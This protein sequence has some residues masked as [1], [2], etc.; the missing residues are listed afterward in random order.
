MDN[1]L[2]LAIDLLNDKEVRNLY[3]PLRFNSLNRGDTETSIK[4]DECKVDHQEKAKHF[5]NCCREE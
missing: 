4:Y 5:G 3:R 1:E 2:S